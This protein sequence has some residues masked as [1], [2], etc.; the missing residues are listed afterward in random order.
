MSPVKCPS[1][2]SLYSNM[3]LEVSV[4]ESHFE[5]LLSVEA[6]QFET[7]SCVSCLLIISPFLLWVPAVSLTELI[8]IVK[9]QTMDR[10]CTVYSGVFSLL[11]SCILK[12]CKCTYKLHRQCNRQVNSLFLIT[13][14][15]NTTTMQNVTSFFSNFL[16]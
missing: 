13:V 10:K 15:S 8:S 3:T 1:N 14:D 11:L 2:G 6:E 16:R 5:E 7:S 9:F 12:S 4:P